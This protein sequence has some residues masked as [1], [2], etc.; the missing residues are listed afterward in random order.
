M[1]A[2]SRADFINAVASGTDISCCIC[3]I[4]GLINSAESKYCFSCGAELNPS[5]NTQNNTSAFEH[6]VETSVAHEEEDK[7]INVFA[8]GL[9]DWSIEPP[10]VMVRRR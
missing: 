2:K 5:Q 8:Q 7:K 3:N 6:V 4:C 9:P 10:Q 1:E